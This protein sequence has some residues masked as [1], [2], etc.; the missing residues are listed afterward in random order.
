MTRPRKAKASVLE[1]ARGQY[2]RSEKEEERRCDDLILGAGGEAVHF[3]QA[4]AS[5]QTP[6]IPDRRYRVRGVAFWWEVKAEDGQLTRDQYHFLMRERHAGC[7][8][9]CGTS[10]DLVKVLTCKPGDIPLELIASVVQW[11]TRGF[12]GEK[13]M[14]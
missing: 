1:I 6:G 10:E 9:G 3:S 12:R 5:K 2:T 7:L 14:A 13:R 4:R 8:G 11:A